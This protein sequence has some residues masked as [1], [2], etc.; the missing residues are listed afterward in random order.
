MDLSRTARELGLWGCGRLDTGIC[1]FEKAW[2]VGLLDST[3][4][5]VVAD[6]AFDAVI[7]YRSKFKDVRRE[8]IGIIGQIGASVREHGTPF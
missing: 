6:M 4:V 3:R 7:G 5:D 8:F 2:S 1:Y